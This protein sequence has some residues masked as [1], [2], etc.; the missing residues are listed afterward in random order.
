[1]QTN[2][3]LLVDSRH[4]TIGFMS[5]DDREFTDN[6]VIQLTDEGIKVE[7]GRFYGGVATNLLGRLPRMCYAFKAVSLGCLLLKLGWGGGG[8]KNI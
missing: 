3:K 2:R 1:V 8:V 5:D 6:V 7:I 4:K